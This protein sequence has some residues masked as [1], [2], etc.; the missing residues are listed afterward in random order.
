MNNLCLLNLKI[1]IIKINLL[2]KNIAHTAT[3]QTTQSLLVSKNNEMM[4]TN[5]M[6]MLGHDLHKNLLYN[7]FALLQMIEQNI[8]IIEIEAE[9]HQEITHITKFIH[10]I[11]TVP[12]LETDLVMTKTLLFHNILDHDMIII[13]AIHGLTVLHIDLP[14][15]PLIYTTLVLDIDHAPI[16]E[17]I[18]FQDIQIL[19]D[20]LPNQ[21]I[22]GFLYLVHT[23]FLEINS[24]PYNHKTILNP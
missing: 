21:D 24:I 10:T 23:L 6:L 16:Q 11:D 14:I 13:N 8:L 18:I 19:T 12:H 22:L 17:T 5:E 7:T 1:Q 15:D 2:I 9:V 3:E 4:K 20:L